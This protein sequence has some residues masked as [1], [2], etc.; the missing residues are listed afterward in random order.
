MA[1]SSSEKYKDIKEKVKAISPCGQGLD[2]VV[3]LIRSL[4][5]CQLQ[6]ELASNSAHV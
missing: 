1:M 4:S 6:N 3:K 2:Y 5:P